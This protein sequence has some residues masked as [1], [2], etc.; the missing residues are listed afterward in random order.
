MVSL[1][2]PE[3]VVPMLPDELSRAALSL[4]EGRPASEANLALTFSARVKPDGL[5]RPAEKPRGD[6]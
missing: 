6:S 1:Y 3:R 4:Y 2:L 5:S